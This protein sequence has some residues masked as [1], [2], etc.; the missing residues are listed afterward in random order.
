MM[1]ALLNLMEFSGSINIDGLS[2]KMIPRHILRSNITTMTQEGVELKGAIRLNVFPFDLAPPADADIIAT[3][4]RVGLWDHINRQGGLEVDISK[5]HFSHGQKQLLFLARAILHQQVKKTK[6]VLVD[7]ATSSL[8]STTDERARELM[9]EAFT[10]CTVLTI[11]HQKNY[12]TDMDLA[13]ELDSGNV[14][15]VLRRSLRTGAW[16]DSY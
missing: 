8:D 13:I 14:K 9:A 10:G 7:E 1:L 3:L 16:V 2:I 12:S 11:A 15:R 5:S 4:E 6:I